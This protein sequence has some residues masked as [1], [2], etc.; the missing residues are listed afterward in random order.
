MSTENTPV[1]RA[2]L[3][4]R[5]LRAE[6]ARLTS[7]IE[8]ANTHRRLGD[9]IAHAGDACTDCRQDL[10]QYNQRII[11]AGLEGLEPA[12]VRELALKKGVLPKVLTFQVP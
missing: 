11:K 6:N 12:A 4:M 1:T 2:E 10:E 5:D 3:E 7:Q 9:I 8:T